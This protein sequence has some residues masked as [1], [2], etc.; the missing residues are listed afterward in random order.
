[1]TSRTRT[2]PRRPNPHRCK[3]QPRVTLGIEAQ[4]NRRMAASVE[5]RGRPN[6]SQEGIA[7]PI[8]YPKRLSNAAAS[9]IERAGSGSRSLKLSVW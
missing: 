5:V 9:L 2:S 8:R 7:V 6:R 1:M 4:M 3:G